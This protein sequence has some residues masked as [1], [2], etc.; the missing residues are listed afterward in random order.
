MNIYVDVQDKVILPSLRLLRE[1]NK[2][3]H[4]QRTKPFSDF[5]CSFVLKFGS[6]VSSCV[7][8]T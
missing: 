1:N 7:R 3:K 8:S 5:T 2:E 4:N 6:N